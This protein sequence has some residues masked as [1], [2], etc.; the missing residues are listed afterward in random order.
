MPNASHILETALLLLA[1]FLIGCV[2]GHLLRRLA[3][4][5]VRPGLAQSVAQPPVAVTADALVVAPVIEPI[6]APSPKPVAAQPPP[7]FSHAIQPAHVAGETT[8]GRVIPTPIEKSEA[9]VVEAEAA[10]ARVVAADVPP[11]DEAAHVVGTAQ[12]APESALSAPI[13]ISWSE[14]SGRPAAPERR[15]LRE[16]EAEDAAMR[17]VEGGWTPPSAPQ[18]AQRRIEL[19]EPIEVGEIPAPIE[20]AEVI[21]GETS[22]VE[23]AGAISAVR[24]GVAAASA[25]AAAAIAEHLA[26]PPA[27]R[28]S[29]A[30]AS[31]ASVPALPR[32]PFGKPNGL[33]AP[34][35]G[36]RDD[37]QRIRGITFQIE[38]ALNEIGVFHFD[39]IAEWDRKAVV[40]MDGHL[41]LKGRIAREKWIEQARAMTKS[42]VV[43]RPARH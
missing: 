2:A 21:A 43:A 7:A 11:I 15:P 14:L 5:Q 18:S 12:I 37:L 26:A 28:P 22:P 8:S 33:A 23:I 20:A 32:S 16:E 6:V 39:Q 13:E 40:W 10:D 17:A 24:S 36:R 42:R 1:A 31:A 25:A 30:P 3:A 27:D 19:P 34:R 9:P 38:S 35:Q 4:G 41:A 29:A